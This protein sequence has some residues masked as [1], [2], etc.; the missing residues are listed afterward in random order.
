VAFDLDGTLLTGT[1]SWEMIHAHFGTLQVA[2]QAHRDYSSRKI[3]YAQF[4]RRDL[5]AWPKPISRGMLTEILSGY[6]LRPEAS[7]V[8][9]DLKL[10]GYE[11]AIVT[12]ALDLLAKMVAYRL[13]IKY[14]LANKIGFDDS[15]NFNGRVYPL[16]DPINKHRALIGLAARVGIRLRNTVAVGDTPYDES[17]LK[18][19][20]RGIVMGDEQLAARLNMPCIH[21]LEELL[22]LL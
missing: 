18:T 8:V 13:R 2:Q 21:N 15:G 17:F 10:M 9:G 3:S 20:G 1:P 7:A 14:V 12:S 22:E 6:R 19:A 5:S 11:V 16:V 4:M